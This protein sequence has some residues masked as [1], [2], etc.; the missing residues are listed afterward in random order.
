MSDIV[1]RKFGKVLVV[2]K[3]PN[4]NSTDRH[5]RYLCRCDC[6]KEWETR[7]SHILRGIKSCG[8]SSKT[9][10][11]GVGEMSG[12]FWCILKTNAKTR[13]IPITITKQEAWDLFLKQDRKCAI[14]GLPLTFS[15]SMKHKEQTASLDRI[16][17]S[18][19]YSIDNVQWL[20]KSI[21][22]MKLN[23]T[24]EEFIQLCAAVAN[25]NS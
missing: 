1:N 22:L 13:N 21:N 10:W 16:D 7:K 23:H 12:Q 14:S 8:C 9:K 11:N 18:K 3:V 25:H 20:H 5:H 24:Q 4:L 15:R 6:G 17:S 19:P 2:K